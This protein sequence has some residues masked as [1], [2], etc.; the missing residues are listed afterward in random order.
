MEARRRVDA[1]QRRAGLARRNITTRRRRWAR[2]SETELIDAARDGD[3]E[4]LVAVIETCERSIASGIRSGG[5]TRGDREYADTELE[6]LTT[7]C[8]RFG[9]YDHRGPVCAWMRA[10]ARN[11]AVGHIRAEIRQRRIREKLAATRVETVHHDEE[12]DDGPAPAAMAESIVAALSPK[13]REVVEAY[14]LDGLPAE[15]IAQRLFISVDTV[16]VRLHRAR[17]FALDIA[18]QAGHA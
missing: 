12:Y 18:R 15:E 14:Y 2:R 4:A 13:Y 17:R 8:D 6:A 7:I 9:D 3:R 16:Y 1:G 5:L 11:I 10:I